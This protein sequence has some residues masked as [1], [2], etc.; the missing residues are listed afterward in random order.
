LISGL[1][2]SLPGIITL[3]GI[4]GTTFIA[5]PFGVLRCLV[6]NRG[7]QSVIVSPK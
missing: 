6:R 4:I 5:G 1:I 7:C 2:T 3:L